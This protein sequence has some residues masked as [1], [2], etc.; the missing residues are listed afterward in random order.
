LKS[1]QVSIFIIIQVMGGI[2]VVN[3]MT[4]IKL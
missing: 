2:V 1:K 3:L 4:T